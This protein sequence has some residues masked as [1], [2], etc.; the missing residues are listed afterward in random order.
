MTPWTNRATIVWITLAIVTMTHNAMTDRLSRNEE[1]V[2]KVVAG[3]VKEARASWWGFDPEDA[4]EA[5]Q[6]AINSGAK[7]LI[8]ENMGSPWIVDKIQLASN[9]EIVLEQGVVVQA[10]RGAFKGTG[11]CLFTAALKENITLVGYGATLR[12]WKEDYHTDAYQKAEWRHTLS[13]RSSKNVKVYGLTL[14]NSGGDGIYLGVSAKGVPNKNIHIKDVVCTDH[15]RQ[16]IS[17]ISAEDLLIENTV[18][19][20]TW[21]TPPQAGIDFEPNEPSERLV[22]CVMRNCVSENNAGDAYDIYIPTL[23]ADSEPVSIRLENCRS[24]GGIRAVAIT[25]GNSTTEAVKG[26]IEFINCRFE[27]SKHAGIVVNRKPAQGCKVVFANCVI[28]NAAAEQPTQTPIMISSASRDTEDIGG[29]EFT[30][31]MVLDPVERNPMSYTDLAG[32]LALVDVT[33]SLTVER[34]GTRQS[35]TIDQ[36]LI[37]LWM[38]HRTYKRFPRFVAEGVQYEPLF[39][40]ATP[41][42]FGVRSP[43]RQRGHSEYL[44]W[45]EQGK[46]VSFTV[47]VEPVGRNAIAP[48]PV[49]LISPSG[50]AKGLGSTTTQTETNFTFSPEETGAYRIVLEPGGNTTRVQSNTHRV[51]EFSPSGSIHFLGTTGQFFFWVPASVREFGIKVSGDNVA[52]RIKAALLDPNGNVVGEQDNIAQAHQFLVERRE[53]GTGEVWSIK[54]ERPSQGVLEDFHVELQAI[55]PLLA[56]TKEGLLKPKE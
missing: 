47:V 35:Y 22:N 34:Q 17:V 38:P 37:D 8:V 4:T 11:D 54:L 29:I 7:R 44:L 52:E 39:P 36:K 6:S 55:P 30:N 26:K 49:S 33:G 24:I 48:V 19:K 50:K 42:L 28:S 27:A 32:G 31:C 51:C 45:A 41:A 1:M 13:I 23:H 25:T 5:L 18:L 21:G 14:A 12:M 40:H 2:K 16:G 56:A 20:N 53:G 10:K 3:Q 46:E 43:A 15:N 9:Q